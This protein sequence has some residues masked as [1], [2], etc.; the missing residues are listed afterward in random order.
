MKISISKAQLIDFTLEDDTG[1]VVTGLAGTFTVQISKN[2]GAFQASTGAKA[3]IGS[4][5]YTYTLSASET[6]TAGP[7]AIKITHASI[8][9]K[10]LLHEVVGSS[11]SVP[12]GTYIL[13]TSEAANVLRCETDDAQ[14]LDLLPQVDAYIELATGRDWAADASIRPE[15]KAAARMLLTLWHENPAM[16][17]SG[18]SGLSWGL[19]AVLSQLEALAL[20]PEITGIPEE[21]LRLIRTNIGIEMAITSNILLEFNHPMAAAATSSVSIQDGAGNT[22]VSTNS[23][24]SSKK[25]MTLNPDSNLSK[26]TTYWVIID[27]AADEYGQ[28]LDLDISFTTED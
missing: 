9:Q 6:N 7:L 3:E 25:I 22:V 21:S 4:G 12:A 23:L 15:A 11:W 13:T 28:T 19:S 14:M 20:L 27:H 10:N 18:M 1:A 2:G 5:W 16:I 8:A 26:A 24:D 17:S